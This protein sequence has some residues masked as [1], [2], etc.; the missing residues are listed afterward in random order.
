M[1]DKQ[2]E[3][4]DLLKAQ[5]LHAASAPVVAEECFIQNGNLNFRAIYQAA[6]I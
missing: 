5:I 1:R 4:S 6:N 2:S 3:V